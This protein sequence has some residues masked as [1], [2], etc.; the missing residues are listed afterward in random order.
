MLT[1]HPSGMDA[2]FRGAQRV[3]TAALP[4]CTSADGNTTIDGPMALERPRM[5]QSAIIERGPYCRVVP[6][7]A[8]IAFRAF[9]DGIQRTRVLGYFQG[10]PLIYGTIAAVIRAR[11][12]RKLVTWR[13]PL[14][15]RRLYVPER[16]LPKKAL[17]ALRKHFD[18]T[19]TAAD[20]DGP[21]EQHPI[22]LMERAVPLVQTDRSRLEKQLADAWC[23]EESSL[24]LMDGGIAGSERAAR[25][26][27][28][29][30]AV[31]THRALYLDGEALRKVLA[32]PE[33]QRSAAFR[34]ASSRTTVASWYLRLRDAGG[35]DPMWGL[36]RVEVADA[37]DISARA[38]EVSRWLLAER[39]PL[40]LP[41][42]RWDRMSYGVRGCEEYLRAIL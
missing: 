3:L 16:A 6:G 22:G 23:S 21:V 7:D 38:D 27:C 9:L 15:E 24:L 19:D 39:V 10:V 11:V 41:D 34:I 14:I 40:A 17:A 29:V 37:D 26:S 13:S 33:G 35:H 5:V 12:D 25:S 2:S 42:G 31:K 20:S 32:M 30:G 8:E 1:Y 28:V 36:L 4:D 18:I